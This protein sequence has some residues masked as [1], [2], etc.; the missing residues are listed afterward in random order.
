MLEPSDRRWLGFDLEVP[1]DPLG[2]RA[3]PESTRG[4]ST[5]L[6]GLHNF[7]PAEEEA[8]G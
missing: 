2:F 8:P 7:K 4:D 1:E 6:T 3:N 5:T